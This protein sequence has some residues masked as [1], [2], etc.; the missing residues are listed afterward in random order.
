MVELAHAVEQDGALVLWGRC[1]EDHVAPFQPVAE[2]LGRH[3]QT[4]S[5]DWISRMPDWQLTELSRLVVRLREYAP[6]LEEEGGD[7]ESSRFRFF[8]AVTATLNELSADGTILLVVDNL[9]WADQPTLLL[10][11][12]ILRSTEDGKLGVIGMY[13]DTEVPPDHPVRSM[14]ADC[15]AAHPV[16]TV[17]LRGLSPT[18]VEALARNWPKAPPDLVPQL[19][20]LTDGNPLFLDELLRQFGD[21][22]DEQDDESHT[23][24]PTD[25]SPTEAIRELVARRV[26]RLPEDVI[27]LLQ[28]AAVA[29]PECEAGIVAEA[30]ELAPDRRLD[31]FDLVE[32][33]RLLRRIGDGFR[34]RYAFNHALVRDAIY[35]ELLR[36]RRV[37]FHHKIAVATERAHADE[38]DN[39]VNELA[40]HFYSGAALADGDKA[41]RYCLAAGERALQL[42]A[43]EE[44]EGHLARSLAVAEEFVPHDQ[45]ARCDALMALAEAQN[46]AGD[47]AQADANFKKAASLARA[48]GDA[49][50]LATVALRAV[51]MSFHGIVAANEEHV[52]LLEEARATLTEEDSSPPSDGD[53]PARA[54]HPHRARAGP[55]G[56]VAHPQRRGGRHGPTPGRPQRVGVRAQRPDARVVGHRVGTRA[57]GHRDRARRDSGRHRRRAPGP[58]RAHV[59]RPWASGPG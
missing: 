24:V 38:L 1:D 18:A 28:A 44:A 36:G 45:T 55:A 51:P 41:A 57:I 9:H 39:Y 47:V 12:H 52:Q 43:F 33:C 5:A 34:D 20:R 7:P 26:S 32:E 58:A 40:Y 56:A 25:L 13:T 50:R 35:G 14:L 54:R 59:A 21:R 53:G 19:C 46:R 10:L 31:A 23:P 6:P 3:F 27:Y 15:R 42:L 48:M 8:E 11:R 49:G 22:G 16:E 37:R 30:A 17:H 4:L 2:A 29:G